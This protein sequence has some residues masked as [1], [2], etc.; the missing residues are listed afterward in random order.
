VD[1][2]AAESTVSTDEG[3]EALRGLK[4]LAS[5]GAFQRSGADA[6]EEIRL[7]PD[8]TLDHRR[9]HQSPAHRVAR[10]SEP[11]LR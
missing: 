5:V 4:L 6:D 2:D 7:K 10:Q 3:H 8:P 11:P 9:L 1:W